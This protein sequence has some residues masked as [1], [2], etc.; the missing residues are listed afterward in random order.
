MAL[1]DRDTSLN[2]LGELFMDGANQTPFLNAIGGVGGVNAKA[3]RSMIF[4]LGQTWTPEAAS[5]P[6]IDEDELVTA[7]TADT[8]ARSQQT[9]TVMIFQKYVTVS[10][11]KQAA[12]GELSGLSAV[13]TQPVQNEMAFQKM[14]KLKKMALDMNLAF[15]TGTYAAATNSSTAAQTRGI[16]TACTT[17]TLN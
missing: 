7:G 9:N 2:Y 8:V 16:I 12:Y 6:A 4:P 14:A 5:M 13:G 3:T 15:L 10:D 17:N 1:T 11:L